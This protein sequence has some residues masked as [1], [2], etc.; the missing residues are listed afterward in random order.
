MVLSIKRWSWQVAAASHRQGADF[1]VFSITSALIV[2]IASAKSK[3]ARRQAA[4]KPGQSADTG[5]VLEWT[6]EG[7]QSSG[8]A[9]MEA[10]ADRVA[11]AAYVRDALAH[12]YDRPYLRRHPL[13]PLLGGKSPLSR[14]SFAVC[15]SPPLRPPPAG[16]VSPGSALLAPLPLP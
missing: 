3:Q 16:A 4:A 12:L 7:S 14:T 5:D 9:E 15:S 1:R 2:G 6:P 8:H 13:G 11:F 10:M